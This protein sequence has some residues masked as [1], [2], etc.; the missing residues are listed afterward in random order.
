MA[1][2]INQEGLQFLNKEGKLHSTEHA[3]YISWNGDRHYYM[4]G[5]KMDYV[6][7]WSKHILVSNHHPNGN[8]DIYNRKY[9]RVCNKRYKA[10]LFEN[11]NGELHRLDG[12][13]VVYYNNKYSKNEYWINGKKYSKLMFYLSKVFGII[14]R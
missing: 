1:I 11:F 4:N 10:V 9:V 7:E 5:V 8:A 12:P 14:N 13:A 2:E 6:D 3:A